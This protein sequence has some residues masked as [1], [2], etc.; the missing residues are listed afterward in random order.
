MDSLDRKK[1]YFK[2]LGGKWF[3]LKVDVSYDQELQQKSIPILFKDVSLMMKEVQW[4]WNMDPTVLSLW[5]FKNK[6]YL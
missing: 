3:Y 6:L 1:V 4:H 2:L 5:Y